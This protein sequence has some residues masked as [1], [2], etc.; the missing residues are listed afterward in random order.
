MSGRGG[1]EER[2]V[3]RQERNLKAVDKPVHNSLCFNTS[4]GADK[5]TVIKNH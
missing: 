3:S 4:P 1:R 5:M 2:D